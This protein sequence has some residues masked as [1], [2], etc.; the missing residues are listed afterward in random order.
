MNGWWMTVPEKLLNAGRNQAESSLENNSDSDE[1]QK[2]VSSKLC[3]QSTLTYE[4]FNGV[5][6]NLVTEPLLTDSA[7][8]GA[9]MSQVGKR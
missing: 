5:D 9:L 7:V 8:V 1:V 4:Q 3:L 2:D 6:I